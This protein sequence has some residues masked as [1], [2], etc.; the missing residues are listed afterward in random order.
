MKIEC[1]WENQ[2]L[3]KTL[4]DNHEVSMDAKPPLGKNQ[5]P[6]PKQLA[7][8]GVSGCTA[9]DVIALLRKYKQEVKSFSVYADAPLTEG[10][11]PVVFQKIDLRYVIEGEV[12]PEKAIEAVELSQTRYCGVSAM[13]SRACPIY[14]HIEINGEKVGEGQSRFDF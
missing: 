6:S 8:A 3:F 11:H 9:M 10:K 7:L 4:M 2:M 1:R 13:F 14:Y 12:D 5:G